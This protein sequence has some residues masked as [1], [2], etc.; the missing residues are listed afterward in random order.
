MPLEEFAFHPH[1]SQKK[2]ATDD[3]VCARCW[4]WKY[5]V[6]QGGVAECIRAEHRTLPSANPSARRIRFRS[7]RRSSPS[8]T[9]VSTAAAGLV[10]HEVRYER[11]PPPAGRPA[12]GRSPSWPRSAPLRTEGASAL[13]AVPGAVMAVCAALQ[14]DGLTFS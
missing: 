3:S 13:R 6:E 1:E 9:T 8:S 14:L 12:P 7:R 5:R 11:P 10:A 2:Q 4:L